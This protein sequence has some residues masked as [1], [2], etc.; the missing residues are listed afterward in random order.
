VGDYVAEAFYL[1]SEHLECPLPEGGALAADPGES[2]GTTGEQA[3][4]RVSLLWPSGKQ[5][6]KGELV[7]VDATGEMPVLDD[8]Y[9]KVGVA[10]TLVEVEIVG[11]NFPQAT[12]FGNESAARCI[13][14]A[15]GA[16][17]AGRAEFLSESRLRCNVTF[18]VAGAARLGLAFAGLAW[19]QLLEERMIWMKSRELPPEM[20]QVR[21][22]T[23]GGVRLS[24]GSLPLQPSPKGPPALFCDV[25]TDSKAVLQRVPATFDGSGENV[26]C[27]V[28]ATATPYGASSTFVELHQA[29]VGVLA[30]PCPFDVAATPRLHSLSPAAVSTLG[31]ATL[32]LLGNGFQ[33]GMF[34]FFDGGAS[35]ELHVLQRKVGTQESAVCDAPAVSE[36]KVGALHVGFA[37]MLYPPKSLAVRYVMPLALD[38]LFPLQAFSDEVL[39]ITLR[40]NGFHPG[41]GYYAH[42]GSDVGVACVALSDRAL[43]CPNVSDAQ[44]RGIATKVGDLVHFSI[45]AGHE[46]SDNFFVYD[47]ALGEE[48]GIA[49]ARRSEAHLE[50][51][52][53]PKA[54][55]VALVVEGLA[56]SDDLLCVFGKVRR[57]PHPYLSN[58]TQVVCDSLPLPRTTTERLVVEAPP[59]LRL[60]NASATHGAAVVTL[61]LPTSWTAA[62]GTGA[63]EVWPVALPLITGGGDAGYRIRFSHRIEAAPIACRLWPGGSVSTAYQLAEDMVA[64]RAGVMAPGLYSVELARVPDL[65][66][67]VT[68]LRLEVFQQPQVLRVS[69]TEIYLGQAWTLA[70]LGSRFPELR[71]AKGSFSCVV[72]DVRINGS[73]STDKVAK[74][75][76]SYADVLA[77]G[78]GSHVVEVMVDGVHTTRSEPL[79]HLIVYGEGPDVQ[80]LSTDEGFALARGSRLE[81]VGNRLPGDAECL[82]GDATLDG[83]EA[84][85]AAAEIVNAS[86]LACVVPQ[87]APLGRAVPLRLAAAGQLLN[88][89]VLRSPRPLVVAIA[90]HPPAA[91]GRRPS[92][93]L[94]ILPARMIEEWR[95]STE[96]VSALWVHQ[97]TLGSSW[98]A[99][100]LRWWR[101]ALD[102]G[103]PARRL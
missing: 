60:V 16:G 10:G 11:R 9:P 19:P 34:C 41:L 58:G 91:T 31:G 25:I 13:L 85:T 61:P 45:K 52:S 33:E 23:A 72:G 40:G 87:G 101:R 103:R 12:P 64:C 14:G 50:V 26:T 75:Q 4:A 84:A 17:W 46:G 66:W 82:F 81:F 86:A 56:M 18:Q 27:D 94:S 83:R 57:R 96:A 59:T 48:G 73:I 39:T 54:G 21:S 24:F 51:A 78:P 29:G 36:P 98:R 68:G 15:G 38:S 80:R 100:P 30:V 92:R 77:V 47:A 67:E 37:R 3:M 44:T 6:A 102:A 8:F 89:S 28:G 69:P 70:V 2:F 88:T 43:R 49:I 76:L 74:C 65:Q 22:S 42:V 1:D 62:L 93:P 20:L 79:V 32:T 55:S 95:H 90:D 99:S 7:G 63:Q 53:A 35:S 71:L 97:T 5:V